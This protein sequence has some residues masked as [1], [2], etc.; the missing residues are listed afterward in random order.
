MRHTSGPRKWGLPKTSNN[1][2]RWFVERRLEFNGAWHMDRQQHTIFARNIGKLYI[3]YS[4]GEH[5][6]MFL[7][8][9]GWWYENS[10]G[11]S[12][13]TGRHHSNARP[14]YNGEAELKREI[15]PLTTED[16]KN[17]IRREKYGN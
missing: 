2:C 3:V 15:K 9:K 11:Y 8:R 14:Y 10:D 7:F 13:S 6:P 4:Y 1:K 17:I 16:M 12:R 5:Y